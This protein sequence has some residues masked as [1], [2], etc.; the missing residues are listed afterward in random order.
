MA[1]LQ[2]NKIHA[3]VNLTGIDSASDLR[4]HVDVSAPPGVTLDER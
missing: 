2:A 4:L 1:V 3:I